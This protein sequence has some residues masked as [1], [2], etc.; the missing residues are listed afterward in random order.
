MSDPVQK[1]IDTFARWAIWSAYA[2]WIEDGWEKYF[3][4]VGQ[5]DFD[6]I[7]EHMET[8]LPNDATIDEWRTANKVFVDRAETVK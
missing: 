7:V 3:P 4:Q 8:L 1:A 2:D 6:L 5:Y